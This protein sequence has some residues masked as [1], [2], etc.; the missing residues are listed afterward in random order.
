MENQISELIRYSKKYNDG[1][2][3]LIKMFQPLIKNLA[4]KLSMDGGESDLIIAFIKTIKEYPLERD[5]NMGK[6]QV[7]LAYIKASMNNEFIKLSK[8]ADKTRWFEVPMNENICE[9]YITGS[10]IDEKIAIR[11]IISKLPLNQQQ[12]INEIYI[13][14]SSE[15]SLAV[16]FN[17]SRQAVNKTKRKALRNLR[18]YIEYQ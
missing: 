13:N 14:G 15:T 5:E 1:M 7:I 2:A 9:D 18:S 10:D 3:E 8:K 16:R 6:Q 11:D 4:R 12:V 17:I